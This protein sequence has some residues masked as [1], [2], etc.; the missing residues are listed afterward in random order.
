MIN[1]TGEQLLGH[2]LG[3]LD[4]A[5]HDAVEARLK[6]DS[7]LRERLNVLQRQLEPLS[8][9]RRTHTPPPGLAERTC[10]LVFAQASKPAVDVPTDVCSP[11]AS[12]G[13]LFSWSDAAVIV[14]VLLAAVLVLVP[15][16]QHT[17]F[18]A[19]VVACQDNLRVLGAAL[20]QYS[21]RH[22]HFFPRIPTK[23]RLAAAGIYAPTLLQEQY[24]PDTTRV[25]C[26]G[27]PQAAKPNFRVPTLSEL[28]L[29][30]NDQLPVM[31]SAMGGSY[32]Y[33]LG[34]FS[35]GTYRDNRNRNR[36]NFAVLADAPDL[37]NPGCIGPNHGGLGQNVLFEDGR[38]EFITT[39]VLPN[40][41]H[42]FLN[43]HQQLCAGTDE[44][45][46][47]LAPSDTPPL[48]GIPLQ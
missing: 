24:L 33:A 41:D 8:R 47:V 39:A 27:S 34:F 11:S 10:R 19:Q 38:V 43:S 23:G 6:E 28:L 1:I 46:C 20:T 5:E 12:P 9:L 16:I 25:V 22:N 26:P 37:L 3:A 32:A 7:Q 48:P 17:R 2:L 40:G 31:R 4:E 36:S 13:W 15:V 35:G 30:S 44:N 14:T 29:A 45:D 18:R 21:D 42:L